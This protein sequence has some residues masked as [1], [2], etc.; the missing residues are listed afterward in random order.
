MISKLFQ[1]IKDSE[2][3]RPGIYIIIA[4]VIIAL[5][6]VG[7]LFLLRNDK[8][9]K[10]KP[11]DSTI[12]YSEISPSNKYEPYKEE[13][14]SAVEYDAKTSGDFNYAEV[15]G[16][17][18]ILKYNGD[19]KDVTL[20]SQI[21]NKPVVEIGS[22]IFDSD[23]RLENI[24]I[25]NTVKKINDYAFQYSGIKT[26]TIPDSVTSIGKGVF[27][28]CAYLSSIKIPNN[29]KTLGAGTFSECSSLSEVTLSS[30][31]TEISNDLFYECGAL[32]SIVIPSNVTK[33]GDYAFSACAFKTAVI[34]DTVTEIGDHAFAFCE[35]LEE[36]RFPQ[37]LQKVS[38]F[39]F[40]FCRA[41]KAARLPDSAKTIEQYAFYGCEALSEFKIASDAKV[42]E[43]ALNETKFESQYK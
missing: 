19:K 3:K 24:V 42:G 29:V 38:S 21:A 4:V 7:I 14:P 17:A 16:G 9:E 1:K 32:E 22:D 37:S 25:P 30:S 5:V 18:I 6:V 33:I 13:T 28:G 31:L 36:V 27:K 23:T 20:P 11:K 8:P 2:K 10:E 15:D 41:L 35:K 40:H 12:S 26:I 39:A 43:F 34:P